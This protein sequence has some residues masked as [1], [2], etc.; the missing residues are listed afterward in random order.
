MECLEV[1]VWLLKWNCFFHSLD[2]AVS[3]YFDEVVCGG[4]RCW[5][6]VKI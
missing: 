1:R 4:W 2:E 5:D 3:R 6:K